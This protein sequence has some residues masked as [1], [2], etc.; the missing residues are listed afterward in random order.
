MNH[1]TSCT[2]AYILAA[3]LGTRLRPLTTLVPK[4]VVPLCGRPGIVHVLELLRRHGITNYIVNAHYLPAPVFEVC[5]A[6]CHYYGLDL[7]LSYEPS[8]LGT[9]GALK[10]LKPLLTGGPFILI[11]SDMVLDVNLLRMFEV[12]RETGA[13]ATLAI[14]TSPDMERYG[15]LGLD[16]EARIVRFVTLQVTDAPEQLT[17]MFIGVHIIEPLLLDWLPEGYPAE[18]N[19]DVYPLVLRAGGRLSGYVHQGTWLEYGDL[20]HYLAT[21]LTLLAASDPDLMTHAPDQNVQIIPPVLI[22]DGC[23]FGREVVVGPRVILGKRCHLGSQV[24]LADAVVWDDVTVED[25][26]TLAQVIIPTTG[27]VVPVPKAGALIEDLKSSTLLI[28]NN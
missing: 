19:R 28:D 22:Q 17:G 9:A 18:I 27:T 5:I 24:T 3:G 13:L 2:T 20:H 25:Y 15:T 6:Y 12:H 7:T 16:A 23:T 8:L 11:N 21:N 10:K 4:P 26:S 1:S 14:R